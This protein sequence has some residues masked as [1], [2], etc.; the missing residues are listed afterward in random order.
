MLRYRTAILATFLGLLPLMVVLGQSSDDQA[1]RSVFIEQ[2]LTEEEPTERRAIMPIRPVPSA[3]PEGNIAQVQTTASADGL[4]TYQLTAT[5]MN[6]A[7]AQLTAEER[8]VLIEA[9]E[10]TDICETATDIRAIQLLCEDRLETRFRDFAPS[11]KLAFSAEERLLGERLGGET[12]GERSPT[13]LRI[14]ERLAKTTPSAGNI[15]NQEIASIVLGSQLGDSPPG[16][17]EDN[18]SSLSA[19]TRALIEA[20]V[21]QVPG[22]GGAP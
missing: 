20:I 21:D 7:L 12:Q 11:R 19:E 4:A 5:S 13:L 17:S 15:E 8:E 9:L 14:I 3:G 6:A 2:A 1:D 10:G 22:S 16:P 18:T